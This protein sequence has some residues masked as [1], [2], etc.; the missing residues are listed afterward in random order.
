MLV[1]IENILNNVK[2][3]AI[4]GHVRPDGDCVGSCLGLY[5]YICDNFKDTECVV[6]LENSGNGL[7]YIKGFDNIKNSFDEEEIDTFDLFISLD[8]SDINRVGILSDVYKKKTNTVCIDHHIS[9]TGFAGTNYIEPHMSSCAEVIF[10]MF[11]NDKIS[12]ETAEAIYTGIIHDT[13]VFKYEA[14]SEATMIAAG[15]LIS[16]GIDKTKIID[17]GFYSKSYRQNQILGRALLESILV[18]D[19]KCIFSTI[20]K[21]NMDF[22]GVEPYELGG[23]VEQLRLTEGVECAIFIYETKHLEYKVSLRSK[24]YVD[25]NEVA[26]YFGGG[27]HIRAAG[28]VMQGTAYDVINNIIRQVEKQI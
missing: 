19:G 24:N 20:S 18:L 2:K 26:A 11:D 28:C 6:F 16:K 3:V 7:S 17:E 5:N 22:Y 23:I 15:K 14:T 10:N 9:N 27:G 25:V 12:K 13:G 21:T 4:S 1:K 8:T